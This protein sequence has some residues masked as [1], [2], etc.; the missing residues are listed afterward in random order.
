MTDS[1]SEAVV[2]SNQGDSSSEAV[3]AS[4]QTA[5]A[6]RR[7]LA[8]TD[9]DPATLAALLDAAEAHKRDRTTLG[10][11]LAGRAVGLLFEK[12]S[13]RTR[14]STEVAVADLG[15]HPA[16]LSADELQLG[17]GEPVA[18][19]ARVLSGYLD[20]LGVRTFAHARLEELAAHADIPVVNLLSDDEHP[21]Q[22]LADLQTMRERLGELA[23]R[24][25]AWVGDG[26]NV[27]ASL[28]VAGA[29][30]G[31]RVRLASPA[32]YELA[33]ERLTAARELA[34]AHGGEVAVAESP[35][36]AAAGADAVA[37]DVWAS[38]G[39]EHEESARR[40]A[41]AGYTVDDAL[42]E[43]AAPHAFALHCLPA[44]RG[45]EITPQVIDGPRSAVWQEAANRLHTAA[46]VLAHLAGEGRR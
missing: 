41:F 46:A 25:L 21:L 1:S 19:T 40:T 30:A 33:A 15:G 26:N 4:N 7:V 31:M 2:A 3:V 36:E 27:A 9:L 42:L 13:T 12:P 29:L 28:A 10:R 14:V 32:G 16:V 18:D 45:E 20:L 37:T 6:P 35:A 24:T 22:A 44:H 17:R 39:Q 5:T 43:R 23:G 11:P 8:V 38:M 34:E